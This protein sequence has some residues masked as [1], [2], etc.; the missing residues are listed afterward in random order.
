MGSQETRSPMAHVGSSRRRPRPVGELTPSPGEFDPSL[1]SEATR[2][3]AE[4]A[5]SK[6]R[7]CFTRGTAYHG[8]GRKSIGLVRHDTKETAMANELLA[9]A[10]GCLITA[11]ESVLCAMGGSH[12]L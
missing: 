9:R 3:V 11:S 1:I 6:M 2:L 8:V 4:R 7:Y 10:C 5:S 12:V